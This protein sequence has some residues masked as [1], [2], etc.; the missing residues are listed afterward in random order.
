MPGF[1]PEIYDNLSEGVTANVVTPGTGAT[2]V[3]SLS[4][5]AP[6]GP[7]GVNATA[8]I[9]LTGVGTPTIGASVGSGFSI[10]DKVFFSSGVTAVV[11]T[12]SSGA[13]ATFQNFTFSGASGGSLEGVGTAVPANPLA[14]VSTSGSGTGPVTMN[15]AWGLGPVYNLVGGAGYTVAPT[16]TL[17]SGAGSGSVALAVGYWTNMAN[18][19]NTGNGPLRGPSQIMVATAGVGTSTPAAATGTL[20]GGQDGTANVT[21]SRLVGVDTAGARTGIY[22][23]RNAGL[24]DAFIAD[25]SDTT[26]ETTLTSFGQSEGVEVHGAGPP[27]E[28]PTS[29][30]AAKM[31][32]GTDNPWFRRWL[33]D[34][35]YWN[36]NFNGTQRLIS[37]ATFGAAQMSTLRP[38]QSGLN[39]Q[40]LGV[41]ATQRSLSGNPYGNDE[42]GTL[43]L[44][45]IDVIANPIPAGYMFGIAI[46]L[47]SSSDKTRNQD[48]WPRLTSFIARSLTGP[49][50][51][52][53]LIGQDVTPDFWIDGYDTLDAYLSGLVNAGT[54]QAYQIQFSPANNPDSQVQTGL[55]VAEV[56]IRYLSIVRIFLINLR[57]GQTVVIGAT[58]PTTN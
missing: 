51:L 2:S 11:A 39:K 57:S 32:A 29:G 54:V 15:M 3:P 20:T 14:M 10:G 46:G 40:V 1:V 4:Y 23:F 42:L 37:P 9:S 49:G 19:V 34:W 38:E 26:Q 56:A 17:G 44:A 12:V 33:G 28:T 50:A 5:T 53:P 31:S 21:P 45:S 35:C 52:G 22:A 13:I 47:N 27:G 7:N 18:A 8:A 36:D 55:V 58:N 41:I 6:S 24:S 16:A 43:D 30:A 25:L 48:N